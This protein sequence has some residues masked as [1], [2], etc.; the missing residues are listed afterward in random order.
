MFRLRKI[1][2]T[3]LAPIS[4]IPIINRWYAAYVL[5]NSED[6]IISARRKYSNNMLAKKMPNVEPLSPQDIKE[7]QS[8]W[9]TYSKKYTKLTN[10]AFYT[11]Y[12]KYMDISDNLADYFPDDFYYCYVDKYFT[13]YHTSI[14][15]DNKNMYDMYFHDVVRPHTIARKMDG[16][17]LDRDYN[18]TS[19]DK[20]INSCIESKDVIFTEDL[21]FHLIK[22]LV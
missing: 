19:L 15:L 12:K 18:I 11:V 8:L 21:L 3:I 6:W 4:R 14:K 9:N 22:T 10:L 7:I 1:L 16:I 13:N 5:V 20:I 17:L 2:K